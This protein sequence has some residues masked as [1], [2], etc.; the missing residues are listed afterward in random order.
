MYIEIG[1]RPTQHE[2]SM[3]IGTFVQKKGSKGTL[4]IITDRPPIYGCWEVRW[5][6]GKNRGATLVCQEAELVA[7]KVKA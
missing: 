5:T 6:R 7:A 4:G 2:A 1:H 3:H